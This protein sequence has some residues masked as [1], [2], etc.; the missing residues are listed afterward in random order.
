M[1]ESGRGAVTDLDREA[2]VNLDFGAETGLDYGAVVDLS[3][4]ATMKDERTRVELETTKR[5]QKTT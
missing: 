1:R 3:H 5:E 4:G 2:V